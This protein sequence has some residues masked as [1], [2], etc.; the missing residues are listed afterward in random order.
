[1]F[2]CLISYNVK[3]SIDTGS[4]T[5]SIHVEDV[6]VMYNWLMAWICVKL[7]FV[8]VYCLNSRIWGQNANGIGIVHVQN[9]NDSHVCVQECNSLCQDDGCKCVNLTE[10]FLFFYHKTGAQNVMYGF[11]EMTWYQTRAYN[12]RIKIWGRLSWE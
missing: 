6:I 8:N 9:I 1:M 4:D 7:C 12:C 11:L 5:E 3:V 10:N 2:S